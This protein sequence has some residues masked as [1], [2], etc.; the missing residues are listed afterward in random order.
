VTPQSLKALRAAGYTRISLG[1]QS[2]SPGVLAILDRRHGAGRA[3]AAALE[4]RD[5]GFEHVNLD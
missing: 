4:A 1:M 2:A 5:A 3:T